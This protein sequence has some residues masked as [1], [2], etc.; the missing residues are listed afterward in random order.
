MYIYI[1]TYMH[2]SLSIYIY[3]HIMYIDISIYSS[4]SLSLC[5]YIYIFLEL[6]RRK[7]HEALDQL[8]RVLRAVILIPP[9]MA[10]LHLS[11]LR[12]RKGTGGVNT[13][14]VTANVLISCV[15]DAFWYPC[16]KRFYEPPAVR[17]CYTI[18]L[19]KLSWAWARVCPCGFISGNK[20]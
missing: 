20:A 7:S 11:C 6:G 1:Y 17:C 5:I 19:Y 16:S 15:R 12:I 3:I 18:L 4:V 8:P 14:G 2:L 9:P 13:N 10:G